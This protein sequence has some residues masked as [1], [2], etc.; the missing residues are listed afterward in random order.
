MVSSTSIVLIVIELVFA[1]ALPIVFLI[2]WRH[3]TKESIVSALVGALVFLVFTLILESILHY[4][5]LVNKNP[6]SEFINSNL[7]IYCLYAALAAGIFEETGR[8]VAFKTLL[9]KRT[10]KRTAITYGIGHGGFECMFVLG[11]TALNY[12]LIAV[13]ASVLSPAELATAGLT[14]ISVPLDFMNNLSVSYVALS[15]LERLIVLP[16]QIAL[17]V[18]VFTAAHNKGKL[19]LFPVA[20]VLHTGFDIFAVLYQ[21]NVIT[22]LW[23][24]ELIL[25]VCSVVVC[26][27]A[28]V[29][30]KNTKDDT[31]KKEPVLQG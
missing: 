11:F 23:L 26:F 7:W 19:W 9:K 1:L 27:I 30:Y 12:I 6:V 5:C 17:S 3:K 8:F 21:T 22:S 31:T 24:V 16:L 20:I 4:F 28:F 15:C 29:I 2:V 10:N 25:L 14:D 13:L 18:L